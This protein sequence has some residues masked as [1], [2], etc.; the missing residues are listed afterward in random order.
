MNIEP[1]K[2]LKPI[3]PLTP[4]ANEIVSPMDIFR[5]NETSDEEI[6]KKIGRIRAKLQAGKRLSGNEKMFLLKHAPELHR[7][8]NRVELQRNAMKEQLKH[9]KSKE[10]ANDI[11]TSNISSVSEKDPDKE[12][13]KAAL[14]EEA[15]AFQSSTTYKS[16]PATRREAKKGYSYHPY[17]NDGKEKE[18]SLLY[19]AQG[20]FTNV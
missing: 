3:Q 7:I 20:E 11:I 8:A 15:K 9:C 19:N 17:T 5:S 13:I 12:Y 16:L 10:E 18:R 4:I 14:Y 1:I 2:S 6:S